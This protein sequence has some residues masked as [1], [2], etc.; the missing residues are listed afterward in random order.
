MK[1]L[2]LVEL[3]LVIGGACF[4]VAGIC[5]IKNIIQN[6]NFFVVRW[7]FLI[8]LSFFFIIGY[9][10]FA[11]LT[12]TKPQAIIFLVVAIV[13]FCGGLFTLIIA[14]LSSKTIN[15]NNKIP[16]LKFEAERDSLTNIYNRRYIIKELH[17]AC[18]RV[19]R[20]GPEC[21]LIF[22]DLNKFKCINDNYGHLIGDKV[23]KQVS[24]IM[25]NSVRSVDIPARIGGDEFI[26]ILYNTSLDNAKVIGNKILKQV[27]EYA[28]N[29]TKC[30]KFGISAGM[31][32]INSQSN[33][34][35]ALLYQADQACYH[36]KNNQS[37]QIAIYEDL[38]KNNAN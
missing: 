16:K 14:S 20:G 38:G 2:K 29:F 3:A 32:L 24:S 4:L 17:Q 28:T 33:S 26:I 23:L 6:T 36:A 8:G 31:T 11:L 25:I 30:N 13:F 12:V 7:K 37:D 21:A 5:Y 15:M 10:S 19:R 27:R 18:E 1:T 22:I 35:D 9:L 34:S